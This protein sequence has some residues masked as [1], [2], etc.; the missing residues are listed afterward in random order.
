MEI[1]LAIRGGKMEN[2]NRLAPQAGRLNGAP[3]W[4][5][6]WSPV[7]L[8]WFFNPLQPMLTL[9]GVLKRLFLPM[10]WSARGC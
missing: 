1:A 9:W 2:A 3:V 6:S 8:W 5:P 10:A 7:P 4:L